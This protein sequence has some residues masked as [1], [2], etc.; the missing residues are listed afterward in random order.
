MLRVRTEIDILGNEV[1]GSRVLC[2]NAVGRASGQ[3][4]ILRDGSPWP[5]LLL[6]LLAPHF[7]EY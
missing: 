1:E 3:E 6:L 5:D 4:S 7:Q 2:A